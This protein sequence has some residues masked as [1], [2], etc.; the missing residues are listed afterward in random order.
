VSNIPENTGIHESLMEPMGYH[1]DMPPETAPAPVD[2]PV[3]PHPQPIPLLIALALLLIAGGV[4]WY[5]LTRPSPQIPLGQTATSTPE[6]GVTGAKHITEETDLYEI[7]A[8]YP[9]ATPL[10]AS[11]GAAADAAAVSAMKTFAEQEIARFKDNGE[12]D[13]MTAED[14][15]ML[16][17]G[18]GRKQALGLEY[19]TYT[20]PATVS[21]VYLIY[22]DT[23]GAHPNAYYRT[24]TF[25]AATGEELHTDDL[26]T[27]TADYTSVLSSETRTR[28]KA[29]L[30]ADAAIDMLEAGTTPDADNFQNFYLDGNALVIVFPPYQVGPYAIGTQEVRIPRA[31]LGNALAARYR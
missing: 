27:P 4:L 15:A 5:I 16:G 30:G 25:D 29:S 10:K 28:L 14:K 17:Y 23:F 20:S 6:G 22:V 19:K 1:R 13:S 21:Y 8:A 26:F 18:D 12:F 9:A 31:S 11:A 3:P 7:D 2:A 24:F